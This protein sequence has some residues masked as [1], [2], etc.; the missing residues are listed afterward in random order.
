MALCSSTAWFSTA[1]ASRSMAF[2]SIFVPAPESTNTAMGITEMTATTTSSGTRSARR[3]VRVPL[4]LLF[5]SSFT[6]RISVRVL[7]AGPR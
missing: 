2:C 1:R 4:A 5:V 6:F 3:I 7:A